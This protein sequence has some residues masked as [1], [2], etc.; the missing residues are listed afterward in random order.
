ML[1]TDL[2]RRMFRRA[3][4]RKPHRKYRAPRLQMELLESR[5]VPSTVH[6][7]STGS[8]DWTVPGNWS[9][10]LAPSYNDD[11]YFDNAGTVSTTN[12]GTGLILGTLNSLHV[13]SNYTQTITMA[14]S[15]WVGTLEMRAGEGGKIEQPTLGL[16][17]TVTTRLDWTSGTINSTQNLAN[18]IISG[19]TALIA[20]A[21]AG[22][23]NTGSLLKLVN[24]AQLTELPGEV[25]FAKGAGMDIGDSCTATMAPTVQATVR[26]TDV[27]HAGGMITVRQGGLYIV[28]GESDYLIPAVY[29][30]KL[31]L[32]NYG[33]VIVR[34]AS[35]MMVT[36]TQPAE[37]GPQPAYYQYA[38][39]SGAV[40]SIEN[41]STL[42]AVSVASGQSSRGLVWIDGGVIQTVRPNDTLTTAK[43]DGDMK[44][45]RETTVSVGVGAN[46]RTPFNVLRVFGTVD[47]QGGTYTP[48]VDNSGSS[49]LWQSDGAFTVGTGVSI[50]PIQLSTPLVNQ[51]FTIIQG[52]SVTGTPPT[53]TAWTVLMNSPT[54]EWD[55]KYTP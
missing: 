52:A 12:A 45:T 1:L 50:S 2:A 24:G 10:G 4:V 47:W 30:A 26:H 33:T 28:T 46:I 48:R 17:L 41:G 19:A 7:I 5:D 21:N 11:V 53:V 34:N 25:D 6:W 31:P 22:A 44:V 29:D 18:L 13:L 43:V 55:I 49:S 35:T 23:V 54:T 37:G 36:V 3:A 20:P 40:T 39:P 32:L 9:T 14:T 27:S 51:T 42:T 8:T 38:D 16:D 15:L